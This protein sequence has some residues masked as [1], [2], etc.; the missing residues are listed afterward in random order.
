MTMFYLGMLVY[1]SCRCCRRVWSKLLHMM[2]HLLAIPCIVLGFMAAWDYHALQD[3]PI[4]HF[5]SIHSSQVIPS[6]SRGLRLP[7]L[8][9]VTWSPT[10]TPLPCSPTPA[11]PPQVPRPTRRTPTRPT[12]PPATSTTP[13]RTSSLPMPAALALPTLGLTPRGTT[14]RGRRPS[15]PPAAPTSGPPS[16]RVL[17]PQQTPPPH[18]LQ[19]QPFQAQPRLPTI[20]PMVPN[21]P[22]HPQTTTTSPR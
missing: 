22:P 14:A 9:V 16:S 20:A 13:T 10:T 3:K 11:G 2:F 1:R 4:P 7:W 18:L 15:P 17:L 12:R 21:P 19:T 8:D 5:Y 6:P